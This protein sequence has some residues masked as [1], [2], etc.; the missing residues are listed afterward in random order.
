MSTA[1]TSALRAEDRKASDA[2][3]IKLGAEGYA[4]PLFK[5]TSRN[6][7]SD[8]LSLKVVIAN[9]VPKDFTPQVITDDK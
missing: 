6:K 8:K 9:P 5:L 7:V 2:L 4:Q 3:E 1:L